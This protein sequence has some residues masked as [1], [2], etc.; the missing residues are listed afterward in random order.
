MSFIKLGMDTVQEALVLGLML[1]FIIM[2]FYSSIDWTYKL[3][4]GVLVFT[5]I[6]VA[7]AANQALRQQKEQERKRL[8]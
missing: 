2:M 3:G 7:T 6:F 4:I 8:R 5:L 1:V